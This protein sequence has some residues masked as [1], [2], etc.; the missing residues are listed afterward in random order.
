MIV[1][2][3]LIPAVAGLLSFVLKS[4]TLRRALLMVTTVTQS[5]LTVAAWLRRPEPV[6]DG[7]LA[8]DALG[9]VF[10]SVVSGLCLITSVY[11]INY[12]AKEPSGK[13]PD[14]EEPVFFANEPEAVFIGC[15]LLF[16]STMTLVTLS[17]NF[18]VLWVAV[19][20][21]T[22]SSAP[23]IYFHRHHR[24][25]E[26]TWKYLV[27]CSVGIALALLGTF[28]LVY[29][30]TGTP[31][32]SVRLVVEDLVAKAT[33]LKTPWLKTAFIFMLVGY[34]TKMGLAPL[35][36]WLPDAHSEAP[37][38][39]SA[40]L[41]GAL[42]NC[43]FLG[44]LRV[45]QVLTAAGSGEFARTLLL[46]FGI[47]SVVT[48]MIFIVGQLD[49]KRLLAYSSIEHMGILAIGV[50]IGGLGT[51]GGLLH[52]VNHSLTKG[53]LF[54]VAGNILAQ[55]RSKANSAVS[56]MF[57]TLPRTSILWMAGLLAITGTPPFG[58]FISELTIIRAAF[59]AGHTWMAITLLAAL[60]IIFVAMAAIFLRMLYGSSPEEQSVRSPLSESLFSILPPAILCLAVLVLGIFVPPALDRVLTE[61]GRLLGGQ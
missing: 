17:H 29:A 45:T 19:E 16:Q 33:L 60:G 41:S 32:G 27:I 31:S 5:A 56:G 40:L 25:L 52:A 51:F 28:F 6:L 7:W 50:G 8:M 48:A 22:L 1:A 35:H 34:G 13:R 18:G 36:S 24:S 2:L 37:S 11:V 53:M 42:L 46:G 55:F 15:L 44:I 9:L 38:V 49:Y 23:L 26:A 12:L 59:A 54:L 58:S 61:A 57:V 39:V 4:V 43:A 30:A 20:A 10:M 47:T 21:T 14:L 3:V